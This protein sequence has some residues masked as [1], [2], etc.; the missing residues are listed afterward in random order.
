MLS[1][2]IPSDFEEERKGEDPSIMP[3]IFNLHR[4]MVER[5]SKNIE[6]IVIHVEDVGIHAERDEKNDTIGAESGVEFYKKW[7]ITYED[8]GVYFRKKEKY[9]NMTIG[10]PYNHL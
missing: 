5:A 8:K 9:L 1:D 6:S 10:Y 3:F 2:F 4:H 7:K